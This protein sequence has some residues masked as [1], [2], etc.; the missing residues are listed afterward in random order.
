LGR[1]VL[2]IATVVFAALM[3]TIGIAEFEPEL[4]MLGG[5]AGA[6]GT[7]TTWW[8]LQARETRRRAIVARLQQRV[9]LFA[10]EKGGTLTV[11]EVAASLNLSLSAAEDVLDQWQWSHGLVLTSSD[12]HRDCD[13]IHLA[14][15]K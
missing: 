12:I 3:V 15:Q 9:L 4:L 8:G 2:G 14:L 11:T 1:R 5:V 7:A 13:I 10:T 6:L